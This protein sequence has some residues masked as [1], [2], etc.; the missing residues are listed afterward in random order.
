MRKS[1]IFWFL[2]LSI[3]LYSQV[4][5]IVDYEMSINEIQNS[6]SDLGYSFYEFLKEPKPYQLQIK[7]NE[8]YYYKVDKLSNG[9]N[10]EFQMMGQFTPNVYLNFAENFLITEEYLANKKYNVKDEI[11]VKYNYVLSR[12]TSKFLGYQVKLATEKKEG[13]LLKVWY[14]PNLPAKFGPEEFIGLPGLVLKVEVFGQNSKEPIYLIHATSVSL[15]EPIAL[16]SLS[17][18]KELLKQEFDDLKAKYE[19]Q[20]DSIDIEAA[21]D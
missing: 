17:K 2:G 18:N 16:K 13:W 5:L 10:G 14:A 11:K 7:D 20:L 6:K 12:E 9:K 8:S 1:F 15:I 21:I 19:S 4:N 3:N